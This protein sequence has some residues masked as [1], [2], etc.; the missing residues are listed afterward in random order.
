VIHRY[1]ADYNLILALQARKIVH[2]AEDKNL[3]DD[4][5]YGAKSGWTAH[6]PVGLEEL[7]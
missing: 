5:L 7:V 6:D 4:N 1:K 3:L 2:N